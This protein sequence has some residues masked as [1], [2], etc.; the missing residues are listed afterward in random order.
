MFNANPKWV[1][2]FTNIVT[3]LGARANRLI[4]GE[5]INNNLY[6]NKSPKYSSMSAD[7]VKVNLHLTHPQFKKLKKGHHAQI[8]HHQLGEG[9]HFVLVHPHKARKIHKAHRAGKGHRLHLSPE[10]F[11]H[12]AHAGGFFDRLQ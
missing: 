5:A 1:E 10:E 4:Q 8:A 11:E 6:K 7:L 2:K 12:T 3:D 9:K